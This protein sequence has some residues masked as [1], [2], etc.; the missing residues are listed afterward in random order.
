MSA[1]ELFDV[2]SR[3]VNIVLLLVAVAIL[4]RIDHNTRHK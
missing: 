3:A 4:A 1:H 2:V